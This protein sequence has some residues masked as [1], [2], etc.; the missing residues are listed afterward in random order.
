MCKLIFSCDTVNLFIQCKNKLCI[1]NYKNMVHLYIKI[2]ILS[3]IKHKNEDIVRD[4]RD[5]L[6]KL[7]N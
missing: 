6:R 7:R 3:T 5:K 4:R 1:Q 2:R